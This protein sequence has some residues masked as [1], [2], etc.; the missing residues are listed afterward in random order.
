MDELSKKWEDPHFQGK[1]Q[2]VKCRAITATSEE[3]QIKP[4]ISDVNEEN[5][6]DELHLIP[7]LIYSNRQ[8]TVI[9]VL[10]KQLHIKQPLAIS[11]ERKEIPSDFTC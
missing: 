4:M 9:T 8:T 2:L 10:R 3:V 1:R 11:E 7:G 6:E 5:L